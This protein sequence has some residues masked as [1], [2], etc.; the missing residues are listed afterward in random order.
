MGSDSSRECRF[1]QDKSAL[2]PRA[3]ASGA[4][5]AAARAEAHAPRSSQAARCPPKEAVGAGLDAY[6][7]FEREISALAAQLSSRH[8]DLAHESPVPAAWLAVRVDSSPSKEGCD[9]SIIPA[10]TRADPVGTAFPTSFLHLLEP[11]GGIDD[12]RG[13][14]AKHSPDHWACAKGSA[15]ILTGKRNERIAATFAPGRRVR[16]TEDVSDRITSDGITERQWARR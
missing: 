16:K 15:S 3:V 2:N 1:F 11:L 7:A 9:G 4:G 6:L 10:A 12:P 5:E 13:D 8:L 14:A